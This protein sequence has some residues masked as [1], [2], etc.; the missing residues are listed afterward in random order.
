MKILAHFLTWSTLVWFPLSLLSAPPVNSEDFTPGLFMMTEMVPDH[1][2]TKREMRTLKKE[3]KFQLRVER[4]LQRMEQRLQAKKSHRGIDNINDP[5]DKWFW[6]WAICWGAGILLSIFAGGAIIG[7][8]IG[9]FWWLLFAAGSVA[10]VVWLV[11]K[12]G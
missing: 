8:G 5:I 6:W 4:F 10:L 2:V 7:A 9:L 11:K 3:E 12:F 1:T